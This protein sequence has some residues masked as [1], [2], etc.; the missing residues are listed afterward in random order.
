MKQINIFMAG[1]KGL[2]D[3]RNALV[4]WANKKNYTYRK[5]KKNVQLNLCS[6]SEAGDNQSIY[7]KLITQSSDIVIFIV[8][9][10]LGTK[11]QRELM[12]ARESLFTNKHP[13][14]WVFT[15]DPDEKTTTY[16]EGALGER[17]AVDFIS[18]EDLVNKVDDRTDDFMRT[19]TLPPR[20][21][22]HWIVAAASVVAMLIGWYIGHT[23]APCAPVALEPDSS[24][25]KMLLI[26]GGGSVANFIEER[27]GSKIP[28]LADYP[29]GYYL[30][31]PTKSAWQMLKEE[32]VSLQDTRRYYPI[33][34]SATEA[35]AKD[36]CDGLITEKEYTDKA[37]I[38]SCK[39]GEDSLAVYVKKD[40]DFL[41][42]HRSNCNK[43]NHISIK[44]LK[45]LIESRSMNVYS[46]SLGSGT[47]AEYCK[48]LKYSDAQLSDYLA[49]PFSESS[50]MSSIP[51]NKKDYL[52]LG[53]QY[54]GMTAIKGETARL[55]VESK[56]AKPML[57][58]FMAYKK[59]N[60]MYYIPNETICLL[61]ELDLTSFINDY[62]SE[63]GTVHTRNM[64]EVIYDT[65][66]LLKNEEKPFAFIWGQGN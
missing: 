13:Q 25:Q 19:L 43:P 66:A 5:D 10:K 7:N 34:I 49:G 39:L 24:N 14:I 28:S 22:W 17:Y 35:T 6:F 41:K 44:Q 29:N 9:G 31:F 21:L 40:C 1:A 45:E 18:S 4:L 64:H 16:L 26:A 15:K 42:R 32:V 27:P 36:F 55:T 30:H 53:S 61:Q 59:G 50:P 56:S 33:C 51:N 63:D 52:L 57:I 20:H 46:T 37:I 60:E 8:E 38:V 54:Y 65:S 58:Y 2:H 62:V 11:T 3:Y 23:C 12:L 47:R 48:I